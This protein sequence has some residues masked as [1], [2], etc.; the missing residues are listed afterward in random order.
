MSKLVNSESIATIF[1]TARSCSSFLNASPKVVNN[2]QHNSGSII[3]QT[4]ETFTTNN[5]NLAE[6]SEPELV[7]ASNNNGSWLL[8][9]PDIHAAYGLN[10]KE[11]LIDRLS[12]GSRIEVLDSATMDVQ[13]IQTS[14]YQVRVLHGLHKGKIGWVMQPDVSYQ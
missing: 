10:N 5:Y 12:N 6:K 3:N 11:L 14:W 4:G 9:K 2:N 7:I 13:G 8:K 1:G